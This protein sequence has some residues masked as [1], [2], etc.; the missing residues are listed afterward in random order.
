MIRAQASHAPGH[1]TTVGI[2]TFLDPDTGAGGAINEK[3]MNSKLHKELITRVTLQG[4]DYLMYK[5][6][7]IDVAIIRATTGDSMGNLT[8]EDES[9][10]ADQ[11][12]MAAAGKYTHIWKFYSN[13]G[14]EKSLEFY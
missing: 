1:I 14:T 3:A 5:A 4:N 12:V 13:S 8:L 10:Y 6:L 2:G 7:P 11:M 9:L